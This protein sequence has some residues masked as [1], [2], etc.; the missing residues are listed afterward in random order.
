MFRKGRQ[1][2][3]ATRRAFSLI[4]VVVVCVLLAILAGLALPRFSNVNGRRAE[5]S[6][7]EFAELI[8][9]A[10]TRDQLTGQAV[11]IDFDGVS[12][13]LRVFVPP[14]AEEGK[15]RST[16]EGD[17]V[18]DP[19]SRSV[20]LEGARVVSVVQDFEGLDASKWRITFPRT[21]PRPRVVVTIEQD[22]GEQSWAIVL[23]PTGTRARV[24]D[25]SMASQDSDSVDL[26]A[27]GRATRAW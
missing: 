9:S 4:E 3:T 8:S 13:R 12:G 16:E 24:E 15:T 23:T 21:E 14:M 27:T 17:W 10:A 20:E 7:K 22:G 11:A 5:A 6:V 26:D 25:P 19:L 2:A 18:P 1:N